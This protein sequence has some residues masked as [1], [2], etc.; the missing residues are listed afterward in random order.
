MAGALVLQVAEAGRLDRRGSGAQ[1][2]CKPR[3]HAFRLAPLDARVGTPDDLSIGTGRRLHLE[4]LSFDARARLCS[5]S[6]QIVK[7]C[8]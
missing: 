1:N 3:P 4:F 8:E 2:V 5:V 7:K 6:C